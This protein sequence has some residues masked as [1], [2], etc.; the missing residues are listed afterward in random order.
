M[1]SRMHTRKWKLNDQFAD[2][3]CARKHNKFGR[4]I[5]IVTVQGGNRSFIIIPE[6]VFNR[7]WG[8]IAL[9]IDKFIKDQKEV[10]STKVNLD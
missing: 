2:F 9:K 1:D 7:G 4:F 3:F 8:D 5:S 10:L 6:I